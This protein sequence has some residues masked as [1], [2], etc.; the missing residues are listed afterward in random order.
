V[1]RFFEAKRKTARAKTFDQAAIAWFENRKR[2][3]DK[4]YAAVIEK[5]LPS[6]LRQP[7][8]ASKKLG[9]LATQRGSHA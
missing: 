1:S 4:K 8:N 3:L 6:G 9:L 5:R 7:L 2:S